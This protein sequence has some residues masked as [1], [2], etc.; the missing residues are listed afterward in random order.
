MQDPGSW[1]SR[2][3]EVEKAQA[4]LSPM[5]ALYEQ[6]EAALASEGFDVDHVRDVVLGLSAALRTLLPDQGT[7]RQAQQ[8]T[9]PDH[10]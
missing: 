2:Q 8:S 6:L 10:G 7:L 3:P 1:S 9:S 5:G 4:S